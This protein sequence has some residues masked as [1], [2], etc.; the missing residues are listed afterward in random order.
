MFVSLS[1]DR[2]RLLSHDA[3]Q[4]TRVLTDQLP[5]VD[6]LLLRQRTA[7]DR[8]RCEA[9]AELRIEP[10]EAVAVVVG[11]GRTLL[12]V[13]RLTVVDGD[14]S[15]NDE[16]VVSGHLLAHGEGGL[17]DG[18][19]ENEFVGGAVHAFIVPYPPFPC[20][21]GEATAKPIN[22]FQTK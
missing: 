2:G 1:S 18:G 10:R 14:Q 3:N 15:L 20:Q 22:Y 17:L 9:A 5:R 21:G 6:H 12:L 19:G 7:L 8:L 4:L 13:S 16:A 11:C